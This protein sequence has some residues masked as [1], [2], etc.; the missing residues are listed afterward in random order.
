MAYQDDFYDLGTFEAKLGKGVSSGTPSKQFGLTSFKSC[1]EGHKPLSLGKGRLIYG[2]SCI[3]PVVTDADVY[4]GLDRGMKQTFR[5][6]PWEAGEEIRFI[7]ED[8]SIPSN[9]TQFTKLIDHLALRIDEGK[10][11]HVGCIGGHG[12]TG[13]VLAALAK[14]LLSEADA[15]NY[16]RQNYCKKAVETASQINF[17][18]TLF[19]ITK[20]EGSKVH[21]GGAPKANSKVTSIAPEGYKLGVERFAPVTTPAC[22][23]GEI[24]IK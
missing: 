14:I 10:K 2:G 21:L 15:V 17:L 7:I 4:V 13:M 8:C 23:W 6:Y 24:K 12:R 18:H 3:N 22:M 20:A 16:V 5:G 9:P 1:Y 11:V 19:G